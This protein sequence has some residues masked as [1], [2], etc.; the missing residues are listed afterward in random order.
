MTSDCNFYK[1]AQLRPTSS[2]EHPDLVCTTQVKSAFRAL[3]LVNSEVI[4][5]LKIIEPFHKGRD[6][7]LLRINAPLRRIIKPL[8]EMIPK[9]QCLMICKPVYGMNEVLLGDT[10]RKV[11]LRE[12]INGATVLQGLPTRYSTTPFIDRETEKCVES[13]F[14]WK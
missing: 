1:V 5:Q 9:R 11:Q 10:K 8:F 2:P 13:K 12:I 6:E 14:R 4:S 7:P 3:W